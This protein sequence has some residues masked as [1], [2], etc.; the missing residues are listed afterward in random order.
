[1]YNETGKEAT[2]LCP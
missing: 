2:C 1:M